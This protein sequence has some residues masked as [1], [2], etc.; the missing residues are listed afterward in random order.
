MLD[1]QK[2]SMGRVRQAYGLTGNEVEKTIQE[3]WPDAVFPVELWSKVH[4]T[5]WRSFADS[6]QAVYGT[7]SPVLPEVDTTNKFFHT[8]LCSVDIMTFFRKLSL[9][10]QAK[11]LQEG[12]KNILEETF[13]D[14]DAVY[15]EERKY[16]FSTLSRLE[17]VDIYDQY[18]PD[19]ELFEEK[20]LSL[21][22]SSY[23][24]ISY[25]FPETVVVDKIAAIEYWSVIRGYPLAKEVKGITHELVNYVVKRAAEGAP[26]LPEAAEKMPLASETAEETPPIPETAPDQEEP[27]AEVPPQEEGNIIRVPAALWEGPPPAAVRDAMRSEYGDA[28]IAYVLFRWRNVSKTTIGNLLLEGTRPPDKM[29]TD[30]KTFRN[31]TNKF[32]KEAASLTIVKT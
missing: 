24:F 32:L 16:L 23:H 17:E 22:I 29:P 21:S 18:S 1:P 4:E 11:I 2:I 8:Y 9:N 14:I 15:P 31:L 12:L 27:A 10:I 28:V 19:S 25:I 30:G 26:L 6:N 3:L 20:I 7:E 5:Y 13:D